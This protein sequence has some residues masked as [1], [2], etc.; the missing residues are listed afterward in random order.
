[1]AVSVVRILYGL[2]VVKGSANIVVDE[3]T[4]QA[5]TIR[6]CQE[7]KCSHFIPKLSDGTIVFSSLRKRTWSGGGTF[8]LVGDEGVL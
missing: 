6:P 2:K 8:D 5:Q 1:M 4:V 7:G 3:R